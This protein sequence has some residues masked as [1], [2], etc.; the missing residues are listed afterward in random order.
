MKDNYIRGKRLHFDVPNVLPEGQVSLAE[1]ENHIKRCDD[2][3][4]TVKNY[5]IQNAF[6]YGMWLSQ[7]FKRFKRR[8][9]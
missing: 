6:A 8:R 1:Y 9:V 7:A 3:F 2:C 4:K 5:V